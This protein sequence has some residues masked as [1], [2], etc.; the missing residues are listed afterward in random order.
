[1]R[2]I[3]VKYKLIC[4]VVVLVTLTPFRITHAEWI[5]A[6]AKGAQ[7]AILINTVTDA[8]YIGDDCAALM[9]L[10][11]L[12]GKKPRT[13]RQRQIDYLKQKKRDDIDAKNNQD[14]SSNSVAA[15]PFT[16]EI[17]FA[18]LDTPE[19]IAATRTPDPLN[20]RYQTQPSFDPLN[21]NRFTIS[22]NNKTI[23]LT[24]HQMQIKAIVRNRAEHRSQCNS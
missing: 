8:I 23:Y 20:L 3:N 12:A 16:N 11:H 18:D 5:S 15:R 24:N 14:G 22:I 7:H 4:C 13:L 19:A 17:K 6:Q 10:K 1:M 9:T 2:P 21:R